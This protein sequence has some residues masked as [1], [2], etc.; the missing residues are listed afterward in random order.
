MTCHSGLFAD[1]ALQAIEAWQPQ[2]L[3][4]DVVGDEPRVDWLWDGY[5]ARG[6]VTLLTSQ[7]KTGKTTLPQA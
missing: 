2:P 5:L 3:V 1:A 7:W 6:S 4:G